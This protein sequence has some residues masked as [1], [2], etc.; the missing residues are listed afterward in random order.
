MAALQ[1]VVGETG[2][3]EDDSAVVAAVPVLVKTQVTV[4]PAGQGLH[5]N[6]LTASGCGSGCQPADLGG[7]YAALAFSGVEAAAFEVLLN[8]IAAT[9]GQCCAGLKHS[10]FGPGG[11]PAVAAGSC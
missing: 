8:L 3:V 4:Y 7:N 9:Q 6:A 1:I 11:G 2:D 10:V 5:I